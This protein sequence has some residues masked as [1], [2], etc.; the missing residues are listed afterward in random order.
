LGTVRVIGC[1][2]GKLP[3]RISPNNTQ[4]SSTP[5]EGKRHAISAQLTAGPDLA[6]LMGIGPKLR[7]GISAP[8]P[9]LRQTLPYSSRQS[10]PINASLA[11]TS[12]SAA[13]FPGRPRTHTH[14]HLITKVLNNN[15]GT[16][17][18]FL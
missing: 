14:K 1:V 16:D 6:Q 3:S 9:E 15:G 13:P 4:Q 11:G 18:A 12:Q 7:I 10:V 8:D 2:T 17:L 5:N